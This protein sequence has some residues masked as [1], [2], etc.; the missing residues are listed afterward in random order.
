MRD[1]YFFP[2]L[3]RSFAMLRNVNRHA[4][5]PVLRITAREQLLGTV[6]SKTPKGLGLWGRPQ[7]QGVLAWETLFFVK[8]ETRRVIC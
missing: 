6:L 1:F 2:F 3:P 7:R 8:R 5:V 4:C